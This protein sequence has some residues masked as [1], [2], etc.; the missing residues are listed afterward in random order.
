MKI[1]SEREIEG[2]GLIWPVHWTMCV[3]RVAKRDYLIYRRIF[4]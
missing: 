4:I 3:K 2:G 1:N